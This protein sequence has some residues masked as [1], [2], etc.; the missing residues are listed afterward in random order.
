L[1]LAGATATPPKNYWLSTSDLADVLAQVQALE[2]GKDGI[3]AKSMY[4]HPSEA[5]WDGFDASRTALV[6]T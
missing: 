5:P 2:R 1:S 6:L 3:E 4:Q